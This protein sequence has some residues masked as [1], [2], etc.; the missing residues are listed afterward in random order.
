MNAYD[1]GRIMNKAADLIEANLDELAALETIDNG[2]PFNV[3]RN[4]DLHLVRKTYR[5]YSGWADKIHGQTI[6]ID[7]PFFC[8][9][10]DEPVGVCA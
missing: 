6:P 2:K 3:A 9:T 7:G 4:I 1:R 8:Y 5:Y 10:K